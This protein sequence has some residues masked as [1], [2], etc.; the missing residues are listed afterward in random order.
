MAELSVETLT[1]LFALADAHNKG[2]APETARE[3]CDRL[4]GK[5]RGASPVYRKLRRLEVCGLAEVAG[6]G[7]YYAAAFRITEAGRSALTQL[8]EQ[9]ERG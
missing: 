4:Y 2:W 8:N 1:I 3:I 7:D 5:G 9:G 6:M